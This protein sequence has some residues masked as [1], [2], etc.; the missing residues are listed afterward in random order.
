MV[1]RGWIKG[2]ILSTALLAKKMPALPVLPQIQIALDL[3]NL[4]EVDIILEANHE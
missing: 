2:K 4:G 1:N 3:R